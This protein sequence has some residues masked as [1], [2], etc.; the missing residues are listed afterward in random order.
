MTG[1][2]VTKKS[3][4]ELPVLELNASDFKSGVYILSV[5]TTYGEVQQQFIIE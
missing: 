5:G 1:R 4:V 2:V 3:K